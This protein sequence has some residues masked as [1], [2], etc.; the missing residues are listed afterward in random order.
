M[1][2]QMK[3]QQAQ[4]NRKRERVALDGARKVETAQPTT[5]GPSHSLQNNLTQPEGDPESSR[6]PN[7]RTLDDLIQKRI[8]EARLL[9]R[10]TTAKIHESLLSKEIQECEFLKMFST[11]TFDYYSGVSDLV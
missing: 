8:G 9:G 11:S 6:S 1:K 4:S 10:P 3:E 5:L 7:V 2:E